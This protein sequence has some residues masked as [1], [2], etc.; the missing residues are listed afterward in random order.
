MNIDGPQPPTLLFVKCIIISADKYLVSSPTLNNLSMVN[1]FYS[2][3]SSFL[4]VDDIEGVCPLING[5]STLSNI[6]LPCSQD[7]VQCECGE[8]EVL[9]LDMTCLGE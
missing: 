5:S 4:P 6:T 1:V 9:G 2:I 3:F 7:M 8:N